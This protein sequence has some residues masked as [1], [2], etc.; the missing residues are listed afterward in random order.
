MERTWGQIEGR[1]GPDPHIPFG[2]GDPVAWQENTG[3]TSAVPSPNLEWQRSTAR[4]M[5]AS[6]ERGAAV[7]FDA[8]CH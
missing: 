2:G 4:K 1:L 7:K 8:I 3:E 5:F 6:Q